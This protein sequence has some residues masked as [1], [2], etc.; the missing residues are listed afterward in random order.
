MKPHELILCTN[1]LVQPKDEATSR[2]LYADLD[3]P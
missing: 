3:I 2:H 1:R